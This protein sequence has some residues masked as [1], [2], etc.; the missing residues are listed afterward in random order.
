MSVAGADD[1]DGNDPRLLHFRPPRAE[2][3][4]M[5]LGW[6]TD[7]EIAQRMFTDVTADPERQR[8]W[9]AAM[10]QRADYRHFLILSHGLPI[11]YLSYGEIDWHNRHCVPGFYVGV[12]D[13]RT[14]AATYLHWYIM[15]YAFYRLDMNK[16]ISWVLDTNPRMIRNLRLLKER[17]VGVLR[18]H[19][20]K[21][22]GWHDVH[23]FEL[24]RADWERHPRLFARDTTLAAFDSEG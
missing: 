10:D 16:V 15:D 24:L 22:D 17:E 20:R 5:I 13:K 21:A 6:R 23:V 7:P 19:V 2:D 3:A 18:Q 4:L 14:A 12:K 11:G 9:L 8:A 1:P